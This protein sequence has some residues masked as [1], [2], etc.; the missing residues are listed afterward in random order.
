M[1][2]R[3]ASLLLAASLLAAAA[4]AGTVAAGGGTTS[5]S[6]LQQPSLRI[7]QTRTQQAGSTV[8]TLTGQY[9]TTG[10]LISLRSTV[11]KI[12]VDLTVA[13]PVSSYS[14]VQ[15]EEPGE[16]DPGSDV[17]Y[18]YSEMRRSDGTLLTQA[19]YEYEDAADRSMLYVTLGGVTVAL[20]LNTQEAVPVSD[21]DQARLDQWAQS[22]DASLVDEASVAIIQQGAGQASPEL[23]LNYYAIAMMIDPAQ[24]VPTEEGAAGPR[25]RD[26]RL[27]G[28]AARGLLARARG[29]DVADAPARPCRPAPLY[30]LAAFKRGEAA[31]VGIPAGLLG[32]VRQSNCFGCCGWGCYCIGDR[33]G[34]P[35]YGT[36][37]ANHDR[38]TQQYR[39]RFARQ[40]AGSLIVA[41][42]YVWYRARPM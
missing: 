11:T 2:N 39:S 5:A 12:D 6:P 9:Q 40:C 28:R 25:N 24:G 27:T 23:L 29:A 32:P 36:P 8:L 30:S 41:I 4:P 22:Q 7:T 10:G 37:C 21:A 20:D 15:P 17:Y 16:Y 26:L 19:T 3:A 42:L 33:I 38:C 34:M 31:F 13:P 14:E 1:L 18:A 35:I